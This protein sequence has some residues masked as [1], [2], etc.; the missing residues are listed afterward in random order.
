MARYD[1]LKLAHRLFMQAYRFSRVDWRPGARLSKPL[2]RCKLALISSAG[3]HLPGQPPFDAR[4][5]RGDCSFRELPS[6]LNLADLQ[7]SHS[8]SAL[9]RAGT[10][11][12]PN[13]AFPLDR[14]REMVARGEVGS[15]N[16]RHF[17]FMGS[18]L[19]P[20]LLIKETAPQGAAKLKENAVDAALLVP[21]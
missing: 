19:F 20:E 18:I 13:M 7:M 17:S 16:S 5:K 2:S 11:A 1:D 6:N 21:V 4:N 8:S 3:L 15:L 12:D 14:L 10:M 9:D